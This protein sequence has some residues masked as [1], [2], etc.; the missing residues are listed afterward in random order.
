MID[1]TEKGR[2]GP[3]TTGKH[4]LSNQLR[5]AAKEIERRLRQ[6]TPLPAAP[7]VHYPHVR[8]P[9]VHLVFSDARRPGEDMLADPT[10]RGGEEFCFGWWCDLGPV[11]GIVYF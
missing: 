10:S 1:S 8:S 2:R 11:E 5:S 7:R 3:E 4:H 6:P 9:G